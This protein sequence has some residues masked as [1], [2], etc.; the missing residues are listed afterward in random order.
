MVH[1]RKI[2]FIFWKFNFGF[3]FKIR[4]F[5]LIL[6]N[7]FIHFFAFKILDEVLKLDPENDFYLGFSYTN[8]ETEERVETLA[9]DV[10]SFLAAAGGNLGLALGCSCLS[11]LIEALEALF[12]LFNKVK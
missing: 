7:Q 1:P 5:N 10:Y 6:W 8:I 2:I 3:L 9:Y 4:H 11:V 12:R